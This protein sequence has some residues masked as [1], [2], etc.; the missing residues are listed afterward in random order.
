MV[1]APHLCA[2]AWPG[3]SMGLQPEL[4]DVDG[5]PGHLGP[6]RSPAPPGSVRPGDA[7]AACSLSAR[8]SPE[9]RAEAKDNTV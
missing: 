6:S 5:P 9:G 4:G 3:P 1:L 7:S 2:G 8:K